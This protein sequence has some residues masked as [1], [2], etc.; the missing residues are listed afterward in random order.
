[1]QRGCPAPGFTCHESA[2]WQNNHCR[3]AG[4][5]HRADQVAGIVPHRVLFL[6]YCRRAHQELIDENLL[7]AVIG[8]RHMRL[9]PTLALR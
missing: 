1:M 6:R 4:Q 3:T 7:D 8:P 9:P 2:T 5:E